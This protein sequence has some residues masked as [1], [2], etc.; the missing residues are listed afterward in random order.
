MGFL[1]SV[2]FGSGLI[3]ARLADGTWSAPSAIALAGLGGGGQFG[4]ELTDFVF[5]LTKDEAVKTFMD[6]G[7]LTIGANI[8]IAFGPGRSAESGAIIGVKGVAGTYA[9]SKTRGV[10]GGLT[11]EG[12]VLIER[13]SAN[14]KIY[15][16]K[17]KVKQL[18]SGE[19]PP[20]PAADSL[21][22]I[23][24]SEAFHRP[25]PSQTAMETDAPT[26]ANAEIPQDESNAA[27]TGESPNSDL[28]TSNIPRDPPSETNAGLSSIAE[29]GTEIPTEVSK[30]GNSEQSPNVETQNTA[31]ESPANANAEH[32]PQEPPVN[33]NTEQPRNV[34]THSPPQE[35]PANNNAASANDI[36]KDTT[37]T[38]VGGLR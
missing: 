9:Y 23:L 35:S 15:E 34:E 22:Q 29:H 7:N 18:L 6:S 12:G 31:Q 26:Q 4:V 13:S 1:G 10:Y 33:V 30:S 19:I 32:L 2:R 14:K 21:M 25:I 17:L 28:A 16:R 8:A 27:A 37:T 11:L 3:V 20:P 36:N 24:S 5:V 38:S